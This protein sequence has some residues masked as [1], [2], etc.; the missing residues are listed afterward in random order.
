M[1]SMNDFL[2][3]VKKAAKEAVQESDPTTMVYG[4]VIEADEET[5]EVALIQI[6]QQWI[7]DADQLIIPTTYKERTV[8]KV[9][10]KG[11]C[12]AQLHACLTKCEIE[13]ELDEGCEEDEALVDV[14]IKD[15]LKA[16]E[17]VIITRQQG[18]QKFIVTGRTG[19]S[20]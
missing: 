6:D 4:T 1:Q 17:P 3:A 11:N 16:G 9:K 15:F 18:G 2:K 20:E 10:I 13:Y 12:I 19:T 7:L 5:G 8:E 14:T